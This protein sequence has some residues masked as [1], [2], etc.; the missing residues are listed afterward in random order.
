MHASVLNCPNPL[1]CIC[2]LFVKDSSLAFL[3]CQQRMRFEWHHYQGTAKIVIHLG[4]FTVGC[5][6]TEGSRCETFEL[7]FGV[8]ANSALHPSGVGKRGPASAGKEKAGMVHYNNRWTRGVQVKL[9]DTLRTSAISEHLRG[10]FTT[11]C[12][13][14]LL[15]PLHHF[16]YPIG[17]K[18]AR[19]C[20]FNSTIIEFLSCSLQKTK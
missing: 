16:T 1:K 15:L 2:T 14:N 12:Y 19:I 20:T 13:T 17:N 18:S 7:S 9:W 5:L 8:H 10:V 6:S 11:R 3:V 4:S